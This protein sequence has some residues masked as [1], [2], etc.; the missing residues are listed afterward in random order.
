MYW[1]E[2]EPTTA[3]NQR[4]LKKRKSLLVLNDDVNVRSRSVSMEGEETANVF[5][6]SDHGLIS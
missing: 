4:V 6:R 5:D 3:H 2:F 1:L